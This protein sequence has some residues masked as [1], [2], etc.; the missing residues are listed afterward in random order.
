MKDTMKNAR[1]IN[2]GL[3]LNAL[4]EINLGPGADT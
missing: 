2:L 3:T 1:K 4:Q